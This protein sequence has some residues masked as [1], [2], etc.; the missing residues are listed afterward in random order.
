MSKTLIK[1]AGTLNP[2]VGCPGGPQADYPEERTELHRE[3]SW[4]IGCASC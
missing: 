3:E 1:E 4:L 2:W